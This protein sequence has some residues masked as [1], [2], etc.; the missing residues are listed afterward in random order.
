M[1]FLKPPIHEGHSLPEASKASSNEASQ[2]R[3]GQS[4]VIGS[5]DV[6]CADSK[7]LKA[8]A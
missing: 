4:S 7:E 8:I 2:G 1:A 3:C 5:A 6:V